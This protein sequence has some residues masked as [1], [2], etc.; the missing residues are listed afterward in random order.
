M[1]NLFTFLLLC[2]AVTCTS[3]K[4]YSEIS[5]KCKYN[6]NLRRTKVTTVTGANTYIAYLNN[7]RKLFGIIG[8]K[9]YNGTGFLIHPRVI[10]TAGHNVRKNSFFWP[11]VKD[12]KM[13]FGATNISNSILDTTIK[14][15]QGKNIISGNDG[16]FHYYSTKDWGIIILDDDKVY[17]KLGGCFSVEI[18]DEKKLQGKEIYLSGYPGSVRINQDCKDD[19][20]Y[21]PKTAELYEDRTTSFYFHDNGLS[22]DFETEHGDSG[23]PVWYISNGKPIVFA[24]HTF[25]TRCN[26]SGGTIITRE[27]YDEIVNFCKS[28]GIDINE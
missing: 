21:K 19:D 6:I 5:D 16:R 7:H 25:G 27:I 26:C 4:T 3:C 13:K 28:K 18:A 20:S 8:L 22:Y 24:I 10:L 15:E 1:K 12:I 2:A 11:N 14:T 23:A 17:Q 9:H